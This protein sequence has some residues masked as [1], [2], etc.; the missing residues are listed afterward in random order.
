MTL[1]IL[2]IPIIT[3]SLSILSPFTSYASRSPEAPKCYIKGKVTD[4]TIRKEPGRGLSEGRT[5]KYIDVTI[6][7]SEK[8][9]QNIEDLRTSGCSTENIITVQMRGSLLG[10]YDPKIPK[11]D[12]CIKGYSNFFGDGNFMSGNWLTVEEELTPEECQ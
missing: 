11:K 9:E 4:V 8:S 12:E 7:R 10:I 3:L 5:F 6:H 1:K 2:L